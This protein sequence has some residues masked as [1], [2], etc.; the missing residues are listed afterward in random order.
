M[1]NP[2]PPEDD[3]TKGRPERHR[4]RVFSAENGSRPPGNP[5]AVPSLWLQG[6][7]DALLQQALNALIHGDAAAAADA[8]RIALARAEG[9]E[10]HANSG[11]ASW[12]L[13]LAHLY[14]NDAAGAAP[15]LQRAQDLALQTHLPTL[16]MAVYL[17][18]QLATSYQQ[19]H[20]MRQHAARLLKQLQDDDVKLTQQFQAMLK[21]A[22]DA[23]PAMQGVPMPPSAGGNGTPATPPER[24]TPTPD[25]MPALRALMLGS[26]R[27]T[28]G[29]HEVGLRQSRKAADILKFMLAH[30]ARPTSKDTLLQ[31]LWPDV[32]VKTGTHRLHL[33][34]SSLRQMLNAGGAEGPGYILFR[35]D[36]YFFNP[37]ATIDTDVDQ[38]LEYA[39]Q[40]QTLERAARSLDA[41][42]AYEAAAE[43]YHDEY[44][45]ENVYDEWTATT[46]DHLRETYLGM[47]GR[48]CQQYLAQGRLDECLAT[49]RTILAKD[50][51]REDAHRAIMRC[52]HLQGNRTGALLQYQSCEQVLGADLGAPPTTL[53]TQLYEQ[54][55]NDV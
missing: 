5:A 52:L 11:W 9:P 40:G 12:M 16:A 31:T 27:V 43:L 28:V 14:A 18:Q 37:L 32:E 47:L 23:W 15:Y 29:E 35:D 6:N 22:R 10:R 3:A 17:A 24:M 8:A 50:N 34:I 36:A 13:G 26:F 51:Y 54:I 44:L 42:L 21:F 45:V 48:L 4:L 33:A 20:Q 41:V 39:R 19:Q 1:K 55:K 25:V 38:F 49:A 30:R 53:T 46:R 7:S 2:R